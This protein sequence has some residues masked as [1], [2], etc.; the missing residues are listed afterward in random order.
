MDESAQKGLK[1]TSRKQGLFLACQ[2]RPG[3]DVTVDLP[4]G[5][6]LDVRTDVLSKEML[7]HNVLRLVLKSEVPFVCEPGQYINL[8][9]D[10]G[11]ARSYSVANNPARDGCIE[12]HIRL[13]ADGLMSGFVRDRLAIGDALLLR[14]PAGNCF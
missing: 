6:G 10:Q 12:L 3:T 5:A 4:D 2:F 7:N 8:I 13:V 9:N 1:P 14:G 11:V